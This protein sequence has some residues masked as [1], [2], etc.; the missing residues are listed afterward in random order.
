MTIAPET[1]LQELGITLPAPAKPV[2]NYVRWTMSGKQIYIAGQLPLADGKVMV[3]GICGNTVT[4][5]DAKHAA[6]QSGINIIAQLSQAC[7]GDLS[8]IKRIL[9]LGGFVACTAD[10]TDH[11]FVVNGASDLMVEVFGDAGRH[12]RFAV[13]ATSLPLNACVEVDCIAE[14]E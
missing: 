10:F 14:I 12:A 5:E 3:A 11:P 6:R 2:A 9:K 1:R 4:K 8:R 7:D 13:G